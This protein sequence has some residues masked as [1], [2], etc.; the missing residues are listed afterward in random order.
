MDRKTLGRVDGE[1]ISQAPIRGPDSLIAG[2]NCDLYDVVENELAVRGVVNNRYLRMLEVFLVLL[3][4]LLLVAN[5]L[6][7]G[8]D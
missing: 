4:L 2:L 8:E 1:I 5:R 7:A 6:R 3:E